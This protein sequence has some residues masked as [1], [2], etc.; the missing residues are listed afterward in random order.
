[1]REG[2]RWR[3]WY[4]AFGKEDD[5]PNYARMGYAESTDGLVWE[6]HPEPVFRS[7]GQD[8]DAIGVSHTHVIAD[9]V[10]GYHLFYV[11]IA[12]DET[13]RMGHAWSADGLTWGQPPKPDPLRRARRV[14][15][16]VGRGSERGVRRWGAAALLHGHDE[17]G[18]LR[19]G[20]LRDDHRPLSLIAP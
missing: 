10:E 20:A 3:M 4:T 9:P 8:F 12:L 14:G 11:G 1:M 7:S 17:A 16:R 18:L 15:R 19:D 13:L 6:K 2:D 5:G